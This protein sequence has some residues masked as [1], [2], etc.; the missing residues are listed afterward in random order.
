VSPTLR[1]QFADYAAFHATRGNQACHFVG[2]P[3]IVLSLFAMLAHVPLAHVAGFTVTTA[4]VL[5]AVVTAYYLTLDVALAALMLAVSIVLLAA[6]RLLPLPAALGLFVSG[7]ILQFVGHYVYEKRSPAFF[8]N[9][10]HL[11][12]GPLWIVAKATG[13]ARPDSLAPRAVR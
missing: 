11:L 2:I 13:R 1:A 5:L 9:L 10:L 8:G 12:V 6:G 7:W 4:E 3:L